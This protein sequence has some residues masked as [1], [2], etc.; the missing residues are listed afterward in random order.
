[1][2]VCPIRI[3]NGHKSLSRN[4]LKTKM[5]IN[6]GLNFCFLFL[7]PPDANLPA[8]GPCVCV[9]TAVQNGQIS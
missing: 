2:Y 5:M 4:K 9:G 1:M 8:P 3:S 6:N 7:S